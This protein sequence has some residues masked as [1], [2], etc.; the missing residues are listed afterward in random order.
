MM[1]SAYKLNKQGD[2]I[3]PW[4]T[5][6][7]IWNQSIVPCLVLTVVF[8]LAY[9][10]IWRQVKYSHFFKNFPQFVVMYTVKGFSIVNEAEI[11]VLLEFLDFSMTQ[12]M[13]AT[14][15]LV[16]LYFLNPACTSGSSRFMYYWSLAWRIL[17]I[18]L[19]VCEMSAT[20]WLSE[21]SLALKCELIFS[22][23][24]ATAEF[25]K[26]AGVLSVA[27]HHLLGL[28]IAQLEFLRLH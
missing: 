25:S 23:S 10:F 6:F 13:F 24:V 14:W 12:W 3:Q 2:N 9:R 8:W 28:E 26:F 20:V 17:S 22:S 7:P 19:L 21:H 15:S 16:P 5:A 4:C 18:T 27:Q 1:S 11:D